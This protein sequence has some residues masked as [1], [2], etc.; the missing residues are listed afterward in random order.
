VVVVD[1]LQRGILTDLRRAIPVP[2]EAVVVERFAKSVSAEL[3]ESDGA[4]RSG[5]RAPV[6]SDLPAFEERVAPSEQRRRR[7]KRRPA[8]TARHGMGHSRSF[9]SSK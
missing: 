6:G 7:Q 3:A 4:P 5:G 2:H 9:S 8:E 1:E